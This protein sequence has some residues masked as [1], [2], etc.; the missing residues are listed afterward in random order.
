MEIKGLIFSSQHPKFQALEEEVMNH[1]DFPSLEIEEK[2]MEQIPESKVHKFP[3]W[4]KRAVAAQIIL[5]PILFFILSP[6]KS[7]GS[8]SHTHWP[9]RKSRVRQ[10]CSPWKRKN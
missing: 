8:S 1:I 3:Q 6:A 7:A 2:V 5:I 9:C 4:F 10:L